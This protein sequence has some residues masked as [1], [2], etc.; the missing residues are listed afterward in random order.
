MVALAADRAAGAA[1]FTTLDAPSAVSYDG[2][3]YASGVSGNTIVG[4]EYTASEANC[5][6]IY[7]G[8]TYT[9][10]VVPGSGGQTSTRGISGP[11]VVGTYYQSGGGRPRLHLRHG[12][13]NVRHADRPAGY[14][15]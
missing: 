15:T 9:P 14:R 13:P 6:F 12:R 3:T 4:T 1:V 5:G 10:V 7:A 11:E 8:G 2:G